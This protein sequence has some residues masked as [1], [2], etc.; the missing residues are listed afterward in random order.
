MRPMIILRFVF[1]PRLNI[2][3]TLERRIEDALMIL[4]VSS[5]CLEFL[6]EL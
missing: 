3:E 4:A 2:L 6:V 1:V 5:L